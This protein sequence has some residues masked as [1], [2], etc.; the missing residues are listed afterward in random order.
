MNQIALEWQTTFL[1]AGF[2]LERTEDQSWTLR[3]MGHPQTE[4]MHNPRGAWSETCAIYGAA[5]EFWQNRFPRLSPMIWSV[6]LGLGY[7]E[8]LCAQKLPG[9]AG[10]VSFETSEPL[11]SFF[12]Q[13]IVDPSTEEHFLDQAFP[14]ARQVLRNWWSTGSLL[15][16]EDFTVDWRK[17]PSPH[18][19]L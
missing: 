5:L 8:F 4:T 15:L 17:A 10:L 3:W 16:L 12:L 14:G 11:R 1:N 9:A 19:V 18:L 2:R 7:N 13:A 6:G